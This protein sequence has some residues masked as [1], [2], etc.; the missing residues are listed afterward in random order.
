MIGTDDALVRTFSVTKVFRDF[1]RREKVAAVCELDLEILPNEVFGL[2]GP[3]GS[4][5]STAIKMI[6]GLLYPTRGYIRVFGRRPTNVAVKS[7]IGFLPEESYLYPFLNAWE[8][9]DYYGR[10]FRQPRP[11]RRRRVEMLLDMVGLTKVAYRRVGEYSKG[12]QRRIGLAQALINDPDLLILDEP[13]SGLDPLGARQFKDVIHQ[14][15]RRGKTVV[16]SSHLLGDVEDVCDRVAILYGGRLRAMGDVDGLLRQNDMTQIT[17]SRLAP[18]TL[19]KV[20]RLLED[21]SAGGDVQVSAPREKLETLF[22][23]VVQTAQDQRLATGGAVGTGEV[24][25]FLRGEGQVD[26]RQIVE[27]MVAAADEGRLPAAG[28]Q[29]APLAELAAAAAVNAE[30]IGELAEAGEALPAGAAEV[31]PAVAPA[32]PAK[33]APVAAPA[34]KAAAP[35]SRSQADRSVIDSLTDAGSSADKKDSHA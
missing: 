16:L 26:T 19:A 8:T 11:E 6:L 7:R 20:R 27:Q 22:L 13:T 17:T 28:S 15:R 14:L 4:G 24:A 9:L 18:A 21:E 3:N 34:S 23:R 33:G 12:M 25:A 1:W 29:A 31:P 5:K 32:S 2:L 35:A 30:V 10:L